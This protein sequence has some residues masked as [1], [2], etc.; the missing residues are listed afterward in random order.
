M[1]LRISLEQT[2]FCVSRW[3][4]RVCT[5]TA[6]C[7]FGQDIFLHDIYCNPGNAS[8]GGN[9]SVDLN[10]I[11]ARER[12]KNAHTSFFRAIE[13]QRIRPLVISPWDQSSMYL[14]SFVFRR[15][16]GREHSFRRNPPPPR[17]LPLLWNRSQGY[18]YSWTSCCL[19]ALS[20]V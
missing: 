19:R 12:K 9:S 16:R 17:H 7:F 18:A 4:V 13:T 10:A 11:Q 15:E 2:V 5:E 3:L 6:W 8:R 20:L 14:G 1:R